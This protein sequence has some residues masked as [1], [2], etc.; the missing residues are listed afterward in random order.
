MSNMVPKDKA[1]NLL[2]GIA[3][4]KPEHV[5][6]TKKSFQPWHKPRKQVVR[7]KQWRYETEKLI[8]QLDLTER[9][10]KYLSLPGEDML[11]IRVLARMLEKKN[12][13]LKCLGF[14]DDISN[15]REGEVEIHISAN[16][17]SN[18]IQEGSVI[19]IDNFD[20]LNNKKSV[21]FR[22]V[23]ENGP[24]DVINLDFCQSVLRPR[25]NSYLRS[26]LHLCEFQINKRR[27][28]WLL[29][30]TTRSDYQSVR[31]D[32]LPAFW[33]NINHN[34]VV[35]DNFKFG[36]EQI[37]LGQQSNSTPLEL[38]HDRVKKMPAKQ[39]TQLF[40]I[41]VGKW[42]IRLMATAGSKWEVETLASY[43]YR[44]RQR[45]APDM[46]ALAFRFKPLAE[47]LNDPS[48]LIATNAQQRFDE[49]RLGIKLLAEMTNL[50]DLDMELYNN[51]DLFQTMMKETSELLTAA[52]YDTGNYDKWAMK[53]FEDLK[54][55]CHF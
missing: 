38:N 9:S 17:V 27:E 30:V 5:S 2:S 4:P 54:R 43:C 26:L 16:E 49:S 14:N 21:A 3:P 12:V 10:L 41:G 6:P 42:L 36:V 52:R 39:F 25:D 53:N 33:E 55:K 28:P 22:Y 46:L 47:I 34:M 29:F 24:F 18:M 13:K 19:K 50:C 31:E 23:I 37:I 8:T 32:D 35:N 44:I 7:N 40:G 20:E 15:T 1:Q 45:P 51:K 11:D 48:G